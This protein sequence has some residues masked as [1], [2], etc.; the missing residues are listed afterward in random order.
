MAKILKIAS[1]PN[2]A[3]KDEKMNE[4]FSDEDSLKQNCQ[5]GQKLDSIL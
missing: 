3:N 4:S 1:I 2:A 5:F